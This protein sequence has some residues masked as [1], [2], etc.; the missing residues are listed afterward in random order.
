MQYRNFTLDQFQIDAVDAISKNES[1]VVAA[2]TGTGK[3][4]IADYAIDM[5]L[6]QNKKIIYTAPIKAL[7]NQKYRQFKEEFG[8][9]R[10][11]LMTG[12]IVINPSGDVLIM[13]V[14]IY[15]NMLMVSEPMIKQVACV[16]F[17]EIHF[18]NDE[19]RGVIW[20]ESI[21]F[22]PESVRFVCLSATI[23]NAHEFADWI[24]SIKEHPVT[25]IE[26]TKRP[27]PLYHTFYEKHTGPLNFEQFKRLRKDF[28]SA[29]REKQGREFFEGKPTYGYLDLL[30]DLNVTR[31][32]PALV[33]VFSRAKC[34][35]FASA[36]AKT[37]SMVTKEQSDKISKF[38]EDSINKD[39]DIHLL[40]TTKTL[41]A[42]LKKGIGFHHAGLLPSLKLLV[43]NLFGQGMLK[44]LFATET[45]AVGIN[46]PAKA[47]VFESLKKFDGKS[48]RYLKTKEYYQMAG[49]AGRRGI[50]DKGYVISIVDLQTLEKNYIE[51]LMEGDVEPIVSQFQL[52]YN[53]VINL[54]RQYSR[55]ECLFVLKNSF[56]EF[57]SKQD[58]SGIP[59]LFDRRV[60][61]LVKNGY[62]TK[63][64]ELTDNGKFL[65][66]IYT[67]S[68][69]I[70]EIFCADNILDFTSFDWLYMVTMVVYE[71][72]KDDR[73]AFPDP[74]GEAK[75]ILN[76]FDKTSVVY[77]YFLSK[78]VFNIYGMIK[79][80]FEGG[81]FLEMM[82]K[83]SL[84][85][86]D[87]IRL[88]RMVIDVLFQVL[89]AT[90]NDEIK[91]RCKYIVYMIE[92]E[93]IQYNFE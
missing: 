81:N 25:V 17:D 6:K 93:Y 11:G 39:S 90:D 72:G 85:E 77:N 74:N 38:I 3:T 55:K 57:Q 62:L 42:C 12:D 73:F 61:V 64:H 69:L 80:W 47:V 44:F 59:K 67:E 40:K 13:T 35:L 9:H 36:L 46:M 16:V 56:Y 27:V 5:Y 48:F 49:R 45:F 91:E 20:E 33:F 71:P 2:A 41:L 75:N 15:R 60:D 4:L 30:N 19:D 29:I 53:T 51:T 37:K 34:E 89:N 78:K 79:Y 86:G 32:V 66:R 28:V 26:Y 22:S 23:P 68:L 58:K 92:R 7:S 24:S 8:E 50:D 82:K 1:V 31:R 83:T 70:S 87:V 88:F 43:E 52:S 84:L 65:S 76:K 10:V 21:I 18:I 63:E 54:V 14:E